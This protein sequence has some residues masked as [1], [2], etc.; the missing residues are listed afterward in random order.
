MRTTVELTLLVHN[1]EMYSHHLNSIK[2]KH[3]SITG[4]NINKFDHPSTMISISYAL[5]PKYTLT[6]V[7]QTQTPSWGEVKGE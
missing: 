2:G 6:D 3:Q 7:S 4:C 5:L 1:A